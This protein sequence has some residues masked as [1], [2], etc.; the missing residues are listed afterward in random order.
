[1]IFRRG[2]KSVV[3]KEL[4][5]QIKFEQ[6]EDG[7]TEISFKVKGDGMYSLAKLLHHCEHCGNIGHSFGIEY[8]GKNGGFDGDGS[9]RI[10]DLKVGGKKLPKDFDE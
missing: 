6:D 5:A 8:D 1:M 2:T 4:A 7:Y 10:A 3:A 9:D